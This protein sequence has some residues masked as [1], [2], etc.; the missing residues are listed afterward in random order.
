MKPFIKIII[1]FSLFFSFGCDKTI[2]E[3]PIK[4]FSYE[5]LTDGEVKLSWH[6]SLKS[7][8]AYSLIVG[9][10]K[11]IRWNPE[12]GIEYKEG[13][14]IDESVHIVGKT[15]D[16]KFTT[17]LSTKDRYKHYLGFG[18]DGELNYSLGREA[19]EKMVLSYQITFVGIAVVFLGLIV[20]VFAIKGLGFAIDRTQ[21]KHAEIKEKRQKKVKETTK[22]QPQTVQKVA[23][24]DVAI[25]AHI[26][27]VI[28]A[29]VAAYMGGKKYNIKSIKRKDEDPW[30]KISRLD[31]M[32]QQ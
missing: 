24:Q 32:T 30:I 12:N 2:K 21:K 1:I 20:L 18:F 31:G 10:D 13:Q 11:K 23:P 8:Q 29:A 6:N 27:V 17:D 28:S 22:P 15:E 3:S 5:Y 16:K 14:I 19:S 25:P 26:L 9:S 4:G 7:P